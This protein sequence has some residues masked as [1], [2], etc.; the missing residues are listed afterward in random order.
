MFCFFIST[1]YVLAFP[2]LMAAM[3]GY[4]T[5]YEPYMEDYDRNL[6]EWNQVEEVAA[7]FQDANRLG[8][9]F[10]K[11]LLL[12]PADEELYHAWQDYLETANLA[13][14]QTRKADGSID[15]IVDSPTTWKMGNQTIELPAPSL[16][17][18]SPVRGTLLQNLVDPVQR[19]FAIGGRQGTLYN[20]SYVRTHSSCKPSETYQWGF[21][22][23][24][25]FMVSIFNFIWSVIMVCMWLDTRRASRMYKSGRRPGLLRSVLDLSAAMREELGAEAEYMEEDE[26]RERL[27]DS[28]GAMCVPQDELR[29]RRVAAEDYKIR[30]RTWTGTLTRGSTF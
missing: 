18:T 7:I 16:N 8:L 19:Y 12:V 21:S 26:L 23:I 6:I 2:T 20:S 28:G 4:I 3:T 5:T 25:L 15:M 17:V 27:T 13:D 11:P 30:K 14:N 9:G 1:L 29:V 24:F 22:Y 10:E